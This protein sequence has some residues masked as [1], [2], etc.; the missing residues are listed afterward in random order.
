MTNPDRDN[1][2]N[3]E[4]FGKYI[5]VRK[6]D[7]TPVYSGAGIPPATKDQEQEEIVG[8]ATGERHVLERP[9]HA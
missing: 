7:G 8:I 4:E 3:A 9:N 6:A 2:S 5:V 1:W